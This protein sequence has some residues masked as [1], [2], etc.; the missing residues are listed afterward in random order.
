MLLYAPGQHEV[1]YLC[2]GTR[3]TPVLFPKVQARVADDRLVTVGSLL[4][5]P[6]SLPL[7]IRVS[8]DHGSPRG[9]TFAYLSLRF[10]D[11]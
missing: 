7:I 11:I 1:V 2:E 10:T 6:Y 8:R 9:T 3:L 4:S 5:L